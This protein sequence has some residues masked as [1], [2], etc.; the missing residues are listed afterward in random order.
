MIIELIM[1]SKLCIY[2]TTWGESSANLYFFC[3]SFLY[4]HSKDMIFS[5]VI[6]TCLN[7]CYFFV[8]IKVNIT[9]YQG[10]QIEGKKIFGSFLW[11]QR[12]AKS[13]EEYLVFS[14]FN[15]IVMQLKK[16]IRLFIFWGRSRQLLSLL[17]VIQKGGSLKKTSVGTVL[18]L[19]NTL[20]L[21]PPSVYV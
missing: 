15:I 13:K 11:M 8:H 4:A 5:R 20:L 17:I 6:A 9:L 19:S 2:M 10:L 16:K 18:N 14:P 21:L 12:E 1:Y 3:K 7:F